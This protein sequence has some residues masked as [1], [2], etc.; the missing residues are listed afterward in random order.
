MATGPGSRAGHKP[1]D[2]SSYGGYGFRVMDPV[3]VRRIASL[4]GLA[5]HAKGTA[6]KWTSDEARAAGR[7]G[8]A[9]RWANAKQESA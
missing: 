3:D 5:A 2:S 6:H 4:G 7:K 1:H 9:Q 8:A